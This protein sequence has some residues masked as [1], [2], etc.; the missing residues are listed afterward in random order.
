MAV[1]DEVWAEYA[2]TRSNALKDEI[3]T[4]YAPL[5][6]N[7]AGRISMQVGQFTDYDDLVGH[8]VFGLIDAVDKYDSQKGVKFETYASF[9]IRGAI[10]DSIRKAD[11]IPRSLRQKKSS[12]SRCIPAWKTN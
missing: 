11:W 4:E 8:G 6:K 3:I 2:K 9:R 12:L 5:V 1:S 7:V 10:I